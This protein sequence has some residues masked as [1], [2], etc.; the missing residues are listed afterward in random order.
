[1]EELVNAFE[2]CNKIKVTRE[3]AKKNKDSQNDP[4]KVDRSMSKPLQYFKGFQWTRLRELR[5]ARV[6]SGTG[7][8]DF[9][10]KSKWESRLSTEYGVR[11]SDMLGNKKDGKEGS[12]GVYW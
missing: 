7:T 12:Y 9:T 4:E 1:M 11:I 10:Y 2:G 5:K 8:V 3:N 6:F